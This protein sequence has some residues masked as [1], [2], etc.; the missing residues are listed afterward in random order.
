L[1]WPSISSLLSKIGSVA[2]AATSAATSATNPLIAAAGSP[3]SSLTAGA[4]T[5]GT[6]TMSDGTVVPATQN[7]DGSITYTYGGNTQTFGGNEN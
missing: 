3:F 7:A 1:I 6:L 5:T 4:A 2:N